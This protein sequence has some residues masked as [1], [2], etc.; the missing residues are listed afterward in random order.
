MR[1][2]ACFPIF[3]APFY[4]SPLSVGVIRKLGKQ[5]KGSAKSGIL[6]HGNKK[7]IKYLRGK[8]FQ[9]FLGSGG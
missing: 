5:E 4:F 2:Y 7:D 1:Y 3:L 9:A 6:C 8:T